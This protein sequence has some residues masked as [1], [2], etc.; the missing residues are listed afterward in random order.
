MLARSLRRGGAAA[1]S[2][3]GSS[4]PDKY[5]L[6]IN[7]GSSSIKFGAFRVGADG[8]VE[9]A[10]G[11]IEEVGSDAQES[12]RL[13]VDAARRRRRRRGRDA[14]PTA[15][16][17]VAR[18]SRLKLVAGDVVTEEVD[19]AIADHGAGLAKIRDV[20]APHVPARAGKG[21]DIGQLQTARISVVFHSFWLI[22]GRAI[23]SRN[24]LDRERLS[25]ERA[26]AE[27]PR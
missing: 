4:D 10:S 8:P 26:R 27:H 14:P 11:V 25:L 22:F 12:R 5:V 21:C 3:F 9:H 23:I 19:L 7:C 24:G 16:P 17:G 18:R 2:F 13:A 6:T 20:L 15:Q 1:R